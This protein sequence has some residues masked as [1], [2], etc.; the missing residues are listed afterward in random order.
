M[1]GSKQAV[2]NHS[3]KDMTIKPARKSDLR[4]MIL[5]NKYLYL[6]LLPVVAYF[7]I[8]HYVPMY[9]AIIAF[10]DFNP[11][12]G[13]WGSPWAGFKYF[14]QF[15]DSYYFVRVLKNTLLLS[16]FSLLIVF[17]ASIVFALLLNEVKNKAAKSI[18]QSLSYL[19]YF[20]SIIVICGM[21]IDFVNPEGIINRIL[22]A[23]GIVSEPV[24]FI[25]M[26][27][28][29]RTIHIG[30]TLWQFVGWNSIIYLAAL[31]GIDPSL[32][33]ASMID[34]AGRWKQMLHITLPGIMPTIVILLILNIGSL[35]DVG[36]EKILLLY[37]P[38]TYETADVISTFVYRRGVLDANYS[39]SSAVG[40]FNSA[41]SF[42]LLLGANR[43][44]RKLTSNSL[45]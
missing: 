8:F 29:Y 42:I 14:E 38:N 20:V 1:S 18:F 17:P 6:M 39:F 21:I 26:S 32:Y 3:G 36:F 11:Y 41:I 7:V 37:N 30:S 35:M 19:P 24:N 5:A 16:F 27:E 10:K 15:F 2:F 9:G 23:T 12:E 13:I 43:L 40:L 44:S 25:M 4:K 34:G 22:L 45:W 31:S 33:E 28:W